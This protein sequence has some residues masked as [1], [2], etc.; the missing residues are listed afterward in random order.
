MFLR[1]S[2][3]ILSLVLCGF[4]GGCNSSDDTPPAPVVTITPTATVYGTLPDLAGT[5]TVM[6]GDTPATITADSWTATLPLPTEQVPIVLTVD[7]E[8]LRRVMINVQ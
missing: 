3:F 6:V 7:G 5:V 4:L 1:P 8:E 2:F